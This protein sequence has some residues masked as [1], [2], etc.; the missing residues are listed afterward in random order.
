MSLSDFKGS[1]E[2]LKVLQKVVTGSLSECIPH[3]Y[4][5]ESLED[6]NSATSKIKAPD[7]IHL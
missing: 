1:L 4:K 7:Q 5:V 3:D 6:H 2:E